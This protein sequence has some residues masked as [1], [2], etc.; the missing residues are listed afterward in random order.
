MVDVPDAAQK[1]LRQ[2]E[3]SIWSGSIAD[4]IDLAADWWFWYETYKERSLDDNYVLA[5]LVFCGMGTLT[6]FLEIYNVAW[7]E[8]REEM[9]KAR[10]TD[11]NKE[12]TGYYACGGRSFWLFLPLLVLL[13]EDVP[14]VVMTWLLQGTLLNLSGLAAFNITTSIYS[15]VIKIGREFFVNFYCCC[16]LKEI[17]FDQDDGG[18]EEA[19]DAGSGSRV[20]LFGG[21]RS[22]KQ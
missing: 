11:E 14:Q 3:W 10:S 21:G 4:D 6:W 1:T 8:P 22:K 12:T 5:L 20:A 13:V 17:T 19:G 15:I 7:R 9:A 18:D 2:R 16:D